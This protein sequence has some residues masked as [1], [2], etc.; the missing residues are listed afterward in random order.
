MPCK[1]EDL[2]SSPRAYGEGQLHD[3]SSPM[4]TYHSS[5]KKDIQ[6]RTVGGCR[7]CSNYLS[8]TPPA[9]N[10]TALGTKFNMSLGR[11]KK[12]PAMAPGQH[13]SVTREV[14]TWLPKQSFLYCS[15]LQQN[16]CPWP[17][18]PLYVF[19]IHTGTPLWPEPPLVHLR[20]RSFDV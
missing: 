9:P 19:P 12:C 2:H 20:I 5:L 3:Q 13:P 7:L 11:N 14:V 17:C 6:S 10:T 16:L 1:L 15:L 8:N 18:A 4:E